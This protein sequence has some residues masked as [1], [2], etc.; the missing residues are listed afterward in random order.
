MPAFPPTLP[1]APQAVRIDEVDAV[2]TYIGK[3][4]PGSVE[5]AAVWQIQRLTVS[6][7]VTSIEWADGNDEFNNVWDDRASLTYS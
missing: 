1:G 5:S 4:D 6:G 7:T 2:D 3:A